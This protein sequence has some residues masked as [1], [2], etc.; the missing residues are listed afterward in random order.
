M[1][2]KTESFT[3]SKST[4]FDNSLMSRFMRRPGFIFIASGLIAF[5]AGVIS[6]SDDAALNQERAAEVASEPS[7]AKPQETSDA[8]AKRKSEVI[9]RKSQAAARARG[10]INFD[11]LK[12]PIEKDQAFKDEMLVDTVTELKGRKVKLRGYILPTNLF[13]QTGIDRFILV[14]D[15]QECCFG[16]GAALYDCV[17]IE[18]LPGK[19]TDFATRPV[20]VTGKFEVDTKSYAYPGGKGPRGATHLAIFK[21]AGESVQ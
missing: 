1:V 13:K 3:D 10:E 5:S 19:T 15:N 18:M 7:A 9:D 20:T 16:P 21:I 4:K 17:V 6:F 11:D 12:F 14:R 8:D 2:S